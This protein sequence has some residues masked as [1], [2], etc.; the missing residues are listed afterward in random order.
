M[1]I[2]NC[3]LLV[4]LRL[5]GLNQPSRESVVLDEIYSGF[6]LEYLFHLEHRYLVCVEGEEYFDSCTA[7]DSVSLYL[8]LQLR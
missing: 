5:C 8:Q 7:S 3:C 2:L 1:I 6:V 4:K